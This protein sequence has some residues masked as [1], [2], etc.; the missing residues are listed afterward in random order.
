MVAEGKRKS[1]SEEKDQ[2]EGA[3]ELSK[4][5]DEGC[6]SLSAA[7]TIGGVGFQASARLVL[8]KSLWRRLKLLQ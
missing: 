3:L 5:Q 1:R 7:E 8:G 4:Q 2:N 6:G